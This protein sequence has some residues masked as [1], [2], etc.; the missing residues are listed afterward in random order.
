MGG[1]E[2][3]AVIEG[4]ADE[5]TRR[6]TCRG[7]NFTC[8]ILECAEP[9][10]EPIVL[11]CGLY[12]NMYSYRRYDKYWAGTAT[13]VC[14]DLP[15]SHSADP[16]PP[17]IGHEVAGDA[18]AQLVD[19]LEL[20]RINL[21]G[22]S[23]GFPGAYRYA[24]QHPDRVARLILSGGAEWTEAARAQV[25][26]MVRLLGAADVDGFARTALELLLCRD[27]EATIRHRESVSR[28]MASR[29][30]AIG[31]E[32]I[33]R[34]QGTTRRAVEHPVIEPGGIRGVPTLCM[35]GEHVSVSLAQDT[36][37][38]AATI[39]GSV[40]TLLRETDHLSFLERPDE[41]AETIVRFITDQPLAGLEFLTDLEFPSRT[42]DLTPMA[43]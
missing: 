32:E 39:E 10:T 16:V 7:F 5:R 25:W 28:V 22:I 37:A 33:E 20:P 27:P 4:S 8:R 1:E 12:Q 15:G 41:W 38:L 35:T 11:L 29:L 21:L 31:P 17:S 36:R 23:N 13:I 30:A 40:F 14:V 9:V 18:V 3:E 26:E 43:R 42:S 34:Y 19:E 24:Q 2:E 6:L